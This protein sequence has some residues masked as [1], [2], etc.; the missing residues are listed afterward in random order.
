M[1]PPLDVT[2]T[3]F[4]SKSAVRRFGSGASAGRSSSMRL[5]LLALRRPTISSTKRAVGIEV[6]EVAAAAQQQR[7]LERPL[8]MAVRAL[9]RAVLVRDAG[10][11]ARSASIAVVAHE[12]LVALRQI[13]LGVAVQVAE[14]RRQAVAAMLLRHAAERPQRILQ[15]LGQRH[16]A[17]AAEHDMGMLEARERQPEVIEPMLQQ[18]RRRS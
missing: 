14:R 18:R 10:V 3:I 17:L 15:A 5:R 4:S 16:E 12:A 11:V 8:E 2:V 1:K 9:D 13:L 7:V 6:V